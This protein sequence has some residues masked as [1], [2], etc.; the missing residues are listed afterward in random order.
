MANCRTIQCSHNINR[1]GKT[2][3]HQNVTWQT[4]KHFEIMYR[5]AQF[6]THRGF[7]S[8]TWLFNKVN[9]LNF[10]CKRASMWWVIFDIC[11]ITQLS[12]P[13]QWT[14]TDFEAYAR[15]STTTTTTKNESM[16][17]AWK[18]FTVRLCL[19]YSVDGPF[20]HVYF[21]SNNMQYTLMLFTG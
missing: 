19:L 1:S 6:W 12:H 5:V 13:M 7:P 18:Y 17:Y 16:K 2:R 11:F 15:K 3:T 8:K 10:F 21:V 14:R 4:R 9:L 20:F